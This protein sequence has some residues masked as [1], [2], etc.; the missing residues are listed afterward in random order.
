VLFLSTVHTGADEERTQRKRK[1][2]A[3]KG[4]RKKE[5]DIQRYFGT[6]SSMIIAIPTVAASYND[7]MNHINRGD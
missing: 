3:K 4:S 5:E 6:N 2:P 1:K 7:K